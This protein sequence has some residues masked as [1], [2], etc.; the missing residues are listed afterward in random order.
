MFFTDPRTDDL[1]CS[2]FILFFSVKKRKPLFGN[3]IAMKY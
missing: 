1:M 2:H 3:P